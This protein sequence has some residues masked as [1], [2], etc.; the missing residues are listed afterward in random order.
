MLLD[1][2]YSGKKTEPSAFHTVFGWVIAGQYKGT[3]NQQAT[4]L[5]ISSEPGEDLDIIL[6]KFWQTEEIPELPY[7]TLTCDEQ[8]AVDLFTHTTTRT[9]EGRYQVTLPRK[10]P[11]ALGFFT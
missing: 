3:S 7:K 9:P 4:S 6:H 2:I 8:T 5:H 1:G 11:F 10:K